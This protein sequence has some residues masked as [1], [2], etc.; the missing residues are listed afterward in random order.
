MY[1]SFL[2]FS[3]KF[4]SHKASGPKSYITL[5]LIF[6]I[7]GTVIITRANLAIGIKGIYNRLALT[8]CCSIEIHFHF[9]CF[10]WLGW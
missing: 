1:I 9:S 6:E 3:L 2:T 8:D 7:D 4:I 10:L 5:V